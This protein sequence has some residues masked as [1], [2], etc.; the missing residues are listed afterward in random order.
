MD[1][2]ALMADPALRR[3]V[4]EARYARV[5]G[6]AGLMAFDTGDIL[7]AG[8]QFELGLRVVERGG[9]LPVLGGVAAFAGEFG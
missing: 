8:L 6:I 5:L 9:L 1:F 7:V 2:I 3:G 4:R